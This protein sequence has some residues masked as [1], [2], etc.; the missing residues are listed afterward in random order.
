[1]DSS[2]GLDCFKPMP[3][4]IESM[5]DKTKGGMKTLLLDA[6]T[7]STISVSLS[8]TLANEQELYLISQLGK[9][10]A[11]VGGMKCLVFCRPTPQ[12][13]QLICTEVSSCKYSE[14]HLFFS[15]ILPPSLLK[16]LAHSDT[17]SVIRGV[18]EFPLDYVP[19]NESSWSINIRK[20]IETSWS[21]GTARE[22][23]FQGVMDR[24]KEGLLSFLLSQKTKLSA[25]SFPKQSP[26]SR[27]LAQQVTKEIQDG[28]Y[29]FRNQR[30]CHLLVLDR[31]D[32]PVTPLLSQWTYQA[33]VHEL[34]GINDGRVVLKGAPGVKKDLE[35][36]VLA[37]KDDLF[38]AENRFSN[39]GELGENI[40]TLL[41]NYQEEAKAND[42]ITSIEDMQNFME[43]YPVFRAKSHNVSKHVALM[44]ELAR[45]VD[46][47]SLMDVSALE[48]E[49][50]V[51][52][53]HADHL[54]QL[55]EKLG[56][57]RIK[58]ADK[59]RLTLLYALRY[60]STGNVPMIKGHMS[61]GGV[62]LD[63]VNLV[64]DLLRYAGEGKRTEGLYGK[65][66]IM[67]KIV[68]GFG[69]V[70]GVENVYSQHVPVLHERIQE[71][72][73]GK[74]SPQAYESALGGNGAGCKDLIVYMIGGYTYEEARV[75]EEFNATNGKGLKV[76]L[77]GSTVLN[78]EGFLEEIKGL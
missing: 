47:C 46:H 48:Q 10:Q 12:N 21:W 5:L 11:A 33:M 4:Y 53:D 58:Q 74:L 30:Q 61:N 38:Y 24:E 16:L 76:V 20:S 66:D 36:V 44:G 13:V 28:F 42:N 59:L 32:D 23:T 45:L 35:E 43:R 63:K 70:K 15:N 27:Y 62:S 37:V 52:D 54:R 56:D 6:S 67:S 73:R 75:V 19:V 22:R 8:K 25:V 3:I 17:S 14:Y 40:R 65:R 31:K 57:A 77:G 68:K 55:I 1:M 41:L 72:F 51:K 64:D 60:E 18:H 29:H 78:S 69:S 9:P 2:S 26:A 49:L 34:L 71:A 50:A 39:F 7:T